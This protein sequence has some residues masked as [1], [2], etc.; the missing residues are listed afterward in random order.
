MGALISRRLE[1]QVAKTIAAS[2]DFRLMYSDLDQNIHSLSGG[3]RQKVLLQRWLA[4]QEDARIII[5]DEP[6]QG[7][8]V[9]VKHE[10]YELLGK[11][12]RE[13]NLGIIFI[14]S[15]LVEVLG[16]SDRVYVFRGGTIAKEFLREDAP[17]QEQ[18]LAH[19][20]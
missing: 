15:E 13:R 8:D 10:I 6:T 2:S 5:F 18:V 3:N 14:S 12:A 11:L 1:G 16:I 19:A 9:G 20:F 17:T 4:R 7:I